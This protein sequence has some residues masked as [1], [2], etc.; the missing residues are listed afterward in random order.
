MPLDGALLSLRCI[1]Q[2]Q[3]KFNPQED[4]QLF[5]DGAERR[6]TRIAGAPRIAGLYGFANPARTIHS[7]FQVP[8]EASSAPNAPMQTTSVSDFWVPDGA[9]H[10]FGTGPEANLQ[11]QAPVNRSEGEAPLS[12]YTSTSQA[13][14]HSLHQLQTSKQLIHAP[15]LD[16]TSY[17]S[18]QAG[19]LH[20]L[21]DPY[22]MQTSADGYSISAQNTL[23]PPEDRPLDLSTIQLRNV[24]AQEHILVTPYIESRGSYLDSDP[25]CF[26]SHFHS[27]LQ[28][29]SDVSSGNAESRIDASDCSQTSMDSSKKDVVAFSSTS[30]TTPAT[31][32]AISIQEL[33]PAVLPSQR[34][35]ANTPISN[36]GFGNFPFQSGGDSRQSCD[37]DMCKFDIALASSI[38]PGTS[39]VHTRPD[40][41]QQMV[42]NLGSLAR[43][44]ASMHD[45]DQYVQT[46]STRATGRLKSRP[47]VRRRPNHR[48]VPLQLPLQK[49]RT[50]RKFA[51]EVARK[52]RKSAS[53]KS[54]ARPYYTARV[55]PSISSQQSGPA[56]EYRAPRAQLPTAPRKNK[57]A[58]QIR[59]GTVS[60][61][62]VAAACVLPLSSSP[63]RGR[64]HGCETCGRRG[65]SQWRFVDLVDDHRAEFGRPSALTTHQRVHTGEKPFKCT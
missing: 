39:D 58:S 44:G 42:A 30:M 63:G 38:Y 32:R 4:A 15:L 3:E 56:T 22:N 61:E 49:D 17:Q 13:F 59:F 40:Q 37:G 33:S 36:L 26:P 23:C 20:A 11:A 50:E 21:E 53:S 7:S 57:C 24:T 54:Y 47:A 27:N 12:Q 19:V 55:F 52:S 18:S 65:Y 1:R 35:D 51:L 64:M 60:P 6:Y 43:V 46:L 14:G 34:A 29:Y 31:T 16:G 48:C 25:F 5:S 9:A 41:E 62:N 10:F 8:C 45:S 28:D 2:D